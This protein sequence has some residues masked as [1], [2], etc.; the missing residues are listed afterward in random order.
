MKHR[1]NY[2]DSWCQTNCPTGLFIFWFSG[3]LEAK[4][5]ADVTSLCRSDKVEVVTSTSA[6]SGGPLVELLTGPSAACSGCVSSGNATVGNLRSRFPV[7][8]SGGVNH[9]RLG[10]TGSS[11]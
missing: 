6:T 11:V 5:A 7:R 8:G 4:H 2:S 9:P 10:T 3:H 1:G